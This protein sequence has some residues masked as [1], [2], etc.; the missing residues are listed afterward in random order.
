M[1]AYWGVKVRLHAFLT[2]EL[3]GGEWSASRR[4]L[5]TPRERALGTHWIGGWVGPRGGL[6]AVLIRKIPSSRRDSNPDHP[7]S[8]KIVYQ[9]VF[10]SAKVKR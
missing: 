9:N 5:F 1:K 7:R 4:G 3:D 8:L 6:D 10:P 2:S